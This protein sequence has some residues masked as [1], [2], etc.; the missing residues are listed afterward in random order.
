MYVWKNCIDQGYRSHH[1][2][3]IYLSNLKSWY[4][5]ALQIIFLSFLTFF[6][7]RRIQ[8]GSRRSQCIKNLPYQGQSIAP[9]TIILTL[10]S[11]KLIVCAE[12]TFQRWNFIN[13]F[14]Q[15]PATFFAKELRYQRVFL[16]GKSNA[17]LRTV[18][19]RFLQKL[20]F[21]LFSLKSTFF[22]SFITFCEVIICEIW[23]MIPGYFFTKN[24]LHHSE[25]S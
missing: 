5:C 19:Q 16:H 24:L 7:T 10:K 18:R 25:C 3:I 23:P 17:P 20:I 2:D 9:L 13:S 14:D 11:Q 22:A 8:P 15:V 6:P 21:L 12:K 4:F 1:S